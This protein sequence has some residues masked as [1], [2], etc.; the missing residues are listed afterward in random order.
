MSIKTFISCFSA[1][2]YSG[3][4]IFTRGAFAPV[5]RAAREELRRRTTQAF[6]TTDLE[7]VT[8]S[9]KRLFREMNG[10]ELERLQNVLENTAR[11][12]NQDI[13][14]T[15]QNLATDIKCNNVNDFCALVELVALEAKGFFFLF[16]YNN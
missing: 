11:D 5:D 15:A 7:E 6:G 16:L 3:N 14:R 8:I 1:S 10:T 2:R 12:Y 9:G 4:D 13:I